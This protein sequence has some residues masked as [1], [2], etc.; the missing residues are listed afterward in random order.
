MVE[1]HEH[2]VVGP[3]LLDQRSKMDD[4]SPKMPRL[5]DSDAGESKGGEPDP[6][7]LQLMAASAAGK[8]LSV[9]SYKKRTKQ[10]V[11]MGEDETVPSS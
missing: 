6:G 9:L 10:A 5:R 1:L 4:I 2:P 11:T 3:L 7:I 8:I